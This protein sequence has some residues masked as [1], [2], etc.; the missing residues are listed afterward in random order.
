M[1]P[2]MLREMG[3]RKLLVGMSG[4]L[5]STYAAYYLKE[6]GFSVEGA[7]LRMTEETDTAEARR[8]AEQV[9]I[10]LHILDAREEFSRF[11]Q[12]PFAESYA[13][14]ETPNPCVE[15]NR[16][17]KIELLCR[18]AR[19]HGFDHVSTGHYASVLRDDASGRYF[20]RRGTDHRKDQSYM[21]WRLTQEQLSMLVTPLWDMEKADIRAEAARLGFTSANAKESQDICFLPDGDYIPFVES[22]LGTFPPGDFIDETGR[23]VGR[24]AGIIRYTVGQRKGLGIALG[25]PVFVTRIDPVRNTVHLAPSGMEYADTAA[26]RDP[27]F[28]KLPPETLRAGTRLRVKIRYAA[29][30]AEAEVLTFAGDRL[31][32]RFAEPQRAVTPG[33]SAVFYGEGKDAE[34]IL[35]GG[36]ITAE[37]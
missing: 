37:K 15:C 19:E 2:E 32:V 36:T 21:L 16:H 22:R 35:L 7:C 33:Q 23:A 17:V 8:A 30:P 5:D 10:S 11:V 31:T 26:V 18:F 12:T 24:H 9:G 34:D 27:V 14:G 1:T 20:V 29:Q 13:R 4:G 3:C 6:N 25:H 28:Q